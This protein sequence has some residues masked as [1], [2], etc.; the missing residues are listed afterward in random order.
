MEVH[1][2]PH[3][4]KKRFK[5]YFLEFLMIFL[6]VTLGFF[7]E[8][9]RENISNGEHA[10][11]LATQLVKDLKEDT[12][13]L[14]RQMDFC[15]NDYLKRIDTLLIA[16]EKPLAV[17]DK[18]EIQYRLLSCGAMVNFVPST[19]AIS[20]IEKELN[21]KQFAT[22]DLP[23]HIAE[24]QQFLNAD[25]LQENLCNDTKEKTLRPFISAHFTLASMQRAD[26]NPS[27]FSPASLFDNQ[28]RNLTQDNLDE[29]GVN[30]ELLKGFVRFLILKDKNAKEEATRLLQYTQQHF[31]VE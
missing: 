21:I 12:T 1:H 20:A 16:L 26:R 24:Y 22:S 8:G 30:M 27:V 31:K 4:E 25:K 3:V 28:M 9:I 2:H 11:L 6:A 10:R 14:Q 17:A 13:H 29:L 23:S 7:A 15:K 19:G 5:E 18:K